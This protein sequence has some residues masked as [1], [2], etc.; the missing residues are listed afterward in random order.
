MS[1]T[2]SFWEPS[3]VRCSPMIASIGVIATF[4]PFIAST[5]CVDTFHVDKHSLNLSL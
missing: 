1:V 3:V 5:S 2:T 4:E